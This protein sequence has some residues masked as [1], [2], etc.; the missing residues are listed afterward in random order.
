[1]LNALMEVKNFQMQEKIV[2]MLLINILEHM[3]KLFFVLDI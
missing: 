1:M 3:E 2:I